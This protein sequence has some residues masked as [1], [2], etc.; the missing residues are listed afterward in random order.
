M[1]FGGIWEAELLHQLAVENG[2]YPFESPQKGWTDR[3][4]GLRAAVE[5]QGSEALGKEE[6]AL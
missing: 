1:G 3:R 4:R 6:E 2:R 5:C